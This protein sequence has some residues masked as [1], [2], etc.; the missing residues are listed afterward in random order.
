[1]ASPS[2]ITPLTAVPTVRPENIT[3]T[4]PPSVL[5]IP[6]QEKLWVEGRI[7]GGSV[8]LRPYY[9]CDEPASSAGI[10]GAWIP[11][12]GAA[13]AGTNPVTFNTLS[14]GGCA[15][16]IYDGRRVPAYFVLVEDAAA[17]PTYDFMHL[18]AQLSVSPQ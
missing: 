11:L 8:S 3:V 18:S 9:W 17:A 6:P 12:G 15:N 4:S 13:I 1:M 2:L 16:G 10:K 14:F 5:Y 7:T